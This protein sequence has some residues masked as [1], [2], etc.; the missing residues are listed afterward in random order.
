MAEAASRLSAPSI[1][2][3]S[4]RST[5]ASSSMSRWAA[6]SFSSR[7]SAMSRPS[8][9]MALNTEPAVV[10]ASATFSKMVV[11]ICSCTA[12]LA[13]LVILGAMAFFFSFS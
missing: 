13:L 12:V 5:C 4:E 7:P 1:T 11:L 3:C 10:R 9:P 6:D 8:S 2:S